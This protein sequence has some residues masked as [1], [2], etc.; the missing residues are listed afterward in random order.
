MD[1]TGQPCSPH[2]GIAP[3]LK[4]SSGDGVMEIQL[5]DM[6][7]FD[8]DVRVKSLLGRIFFSRNMFR[9]DGSAN[10]VY[11]SADLDPLYTGYP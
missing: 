1:M 6:S 4:C 8:H 5:G 11:F 7:N 10:A 3:Q 9:F 2:A